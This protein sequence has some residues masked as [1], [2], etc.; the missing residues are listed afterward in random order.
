MGR[1]FP[2]S[3]LTLQAYVRDADGVLT[4]ANDVNFFWR[5]KSWPFGRNDEVGTVG[6]FGTGQ[7]EVTITPLES[8]NLY[9]RWEISSPDMVEES[10]INI[11]ETQFPAQV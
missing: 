6:T 3:S 10:I 5:M 7:Y 11:A 2:G 8:G 1:L 4:N 9:Y